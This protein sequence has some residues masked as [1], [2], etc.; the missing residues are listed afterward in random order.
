MKTEQEIRD[1]LAEISAKI[2]RMYHELKHGNMSEKDCN[3]IRDVLQ[4]REDILEWVLES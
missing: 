1:R 4:I 3:D 2:D